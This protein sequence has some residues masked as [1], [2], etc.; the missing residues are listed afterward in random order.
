[1][2]K[3]PV[4][5]SDQEGI[6]DAVNY[7]LSG[8]SG[9]GQNFGGFSSYTPVYVR[10]TVKGPFTLPIDTTLDTNITL[11]VPINNIVNV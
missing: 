4:E 11:T 5:I 8:P 10:P 7:L 1:M 9:L 3:F 6:V 2:S